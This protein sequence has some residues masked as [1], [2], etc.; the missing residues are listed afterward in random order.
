MAKIDEI[1]EGL[2]HYRKPGV[3]FKSH[4]PWEDAAT[5]IPGLSDTDKQT[6][7]ANGA[8]EK[9]I[10]LGGDT[11]PPRHMPDSVFKAMAHALV[12]LAKSGQEQVA[13]GLA[14]CARLLLDEDGA[15]EYFAG[16]RLEAVYAAKG[17][18]AL[19]TPEIAAA[20]F[21]HTFVR[22]RAAIES[23]TCDMNVPYVHQE[24]MGRIPNWTG[25]TESGIAITGW[26][27]MN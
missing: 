5:Q 2:G 18:E 19:V 1:L 8:V 24:L 17:S 20:V 11:V 15:V 27:I 23:G 6:L 25:Q 7:V 14:G 3:Y 26:Y 16:R 22:N 12:A 10:T 4:D 9:L 21:S 13:E